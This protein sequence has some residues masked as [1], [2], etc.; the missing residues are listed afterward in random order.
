M[1]IK[2]IL[3]IAILT[4]LLAIGIT[5]AQWGVQPPTGN[6]ES[7]DNIKYQQPEGDGW[8]VSH[9]NHYPVGTNDL[10]HNLYVSTYDYR[11]WPSGEDIALHVPA[12]GIQIIFWCSGEEEYLP[13]PESFTILET[14][15]DKPPEEEGVDF[16]IWGG[17]YCKAAVYDLENPES[18]AIVSGITTDLPDEGDDVKWG[19]HSWKVHFTYVEQTPT[20]EPTDTPE[21]TPTNTPIPTDTPEPT[22]TPTPGPIPCPG[23]AFLL[24]LIPALC[25]KIFL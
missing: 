8:Y 15:T 12:K 5:F 23:A 14:W 7:Y 17:Q 13:L 3:F 4:T 16:P 9:I 24:L 21:P 11:L 10:R 1:K 20:P 18:S 2:A 19:H 22:S 6:W 25:V